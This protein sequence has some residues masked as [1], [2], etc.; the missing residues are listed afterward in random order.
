MTG[1]V[2]GL[3]SLDRA[4]IVLMRCVGDDGEHLPKR[5]VQHRSSLYEMVGQEVGGSCSRRRRF[6]GQEG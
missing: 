6:M 1:G 4:V 3:W 5:V 2:G